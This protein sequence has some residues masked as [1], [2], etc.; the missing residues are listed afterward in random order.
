MIIGIYLDSVDHYYFFK[1]FLTINKNYKFIL[2]TNRVSLKLLNSEILI[3]PYNRKSKNVY[4]ERYINLKED[5]LSI[6]KEQLIIC[7][8][9]CF[10]FL[11]NE[12]E[13]YSKIDLFFIWNGSSIIDLAIKDF[14]K[15]NNSNLLF[16]ENPNI[17]GKCFVDRNGTNA[18]SELYTNKKI[19]SQFKES[20]GFSSWRENYI[21]EKL[22][23][24][25]VPQSKSICKINYY[26]FFDF[27][28]YIF[29][30]TVCNEELNIFKKIKNKFRN[31]KIKFDNVNLVDV[32]FVFYPMQ[33][34]S[35]TQLLINSEL[36]NLQA[37][38][39][40]LSKISN[41]N[42]LLLVKPHPAE[43]DKNIFK[44]IEHLKKFSNIRIVND[45]TFDLIRNSE[46]VYT[47][48][49]TVGLEAKLFEKNVF[50]FGKAFYNDF[51][52]SDL[53]N[54][55]MNYLIDID[56]F[57]NEVLNQDQFDKLLARQ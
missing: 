12:L 42:L 23:Y 39:I 41:T 8:N 27:L 56:V 31:N 57:N 20:K 46:E 43:P 25:H 24:H 28:G 35:D 38:N 4:N 37:I 3:I 47:I 16:F 22:N 54:Y 21:K 29:H 49:S 32:K 45:N 55:I 17:T 51:N 19:L 36:N 26:Y 9:S 30:L 1:K 34:E 2:F 7:Y 50:L 33:V 11:E 6:S 5:F 44:K 40:I 52:D 13:K 53:N 14:A 10:S 15:K 18:Q 48:N